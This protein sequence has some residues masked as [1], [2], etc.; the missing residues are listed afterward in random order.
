MMEKLMEEPMERSA[1][2]KQHNYRFTTTSDNI[3]L[4]HCGNC[5]N[6]CPYKRMKN[7][8]CLAMVSY[9]IP[10]EKRNVDRRCGLCDLWVAK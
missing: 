2:N 7:D 4:K 1:F 3:Y 8:E 6:L 5:G 10:L 9:G